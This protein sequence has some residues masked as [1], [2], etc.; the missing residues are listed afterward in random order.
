MTRHLFFLLGMK[1]DQEASV[2]FRAADAPCLDTILTVRNVLRNGCQPHQRH[3]NRPRWQN[4]YISPLLTTLAYCYCLLP[5][6]S[7]L[8][9]T[10]YCHPRVEGLVRRWLLKTRWLRRLEYQD[11]TTIIKSAIYH[12]WVSLKTEEGVFQRVFGQ[13][14]RA[15]QLP[16]L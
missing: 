2:A 4:R 3:F 12:F 11:V 16:R 15:R 14:L 1:I 9:P 5:I 8:L 10:C 13:Y 7:C 6:A